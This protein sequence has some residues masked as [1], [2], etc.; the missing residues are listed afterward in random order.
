MLGDLVKHLERGA[1]DLLAGVCQGD[2]IVDLSLVLEKS[3]R[4][5]RKVAGKTGVD[6][7]AHDGIV[8]G[9]AVLKL[10]NNLPVFTSQIN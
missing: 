3:I 9:S 2:R 4:L 6:E 5:Q 1:L 8:I 10:V 7:T